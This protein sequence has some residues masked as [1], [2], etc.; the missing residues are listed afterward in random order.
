MSNLREDVT[1][2]AGIFTE[3]DEDE[4]IDDYEELP[5]PKGMSIDKEKGKVFWN[6]KHVGTAPVKGEAVFIYKKECPKEIIDYF[7]ESKYE[8]KKEEV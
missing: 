4:Y 7:K 2:L 5:M 6:N 3:E 8:I 1:R